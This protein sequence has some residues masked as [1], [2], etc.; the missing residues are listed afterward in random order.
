MEGNG[1]VT[2]RKSSMVVPPTM[3]PNGVEYSVHTL[4]RSL[5]Q[6]LQ[7]VFPSLPLGRR[8]ADREQSD[9]SATP[10]ELLIVP[11]CQRSALELVNW[12][13]D[14]AFEK[15]LLLERFAAWAAEVCRLLAE[16]SDSSDSSSTR[17]WADYVDPC[18]GLPVRTPH[19][20]VVYAEVDAFETLLKWKTYNASGCK[21][22]SH[23][24]WG[25]AVYPA[26]LFTTAPLPAL[27]A[28]VEK[29]AVTVAC[30]TRE[31]FAAKRAAAEAA[32]T[33]AASSGPIASTSGAKSS[34][35]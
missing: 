7:L 18:S 9:A 10:V 1:G 33:A 11:T 15:D 2:A 20:T 5:R 28:A 22:L 4:P 8:A 14:A 24:S 3:L 21:V 6:D 29:A 13:P 26:T 12:G 30:I 27:I 34:S 32:E 16:S 23:P 35:S 17:V 31:E 25:T 19:C